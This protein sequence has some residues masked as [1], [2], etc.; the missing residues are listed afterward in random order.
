MLTTL[1][2][3][4]TALVEISTT[5]VFVATSVAAAVATIVLPPLISPV[6]TVSAFTGLI[7]G[8]LS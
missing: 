3:R 1:S 7:D 5:S 8:R 6:V 2:N 4:L